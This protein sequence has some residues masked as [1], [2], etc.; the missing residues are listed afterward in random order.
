M[1]NGSGPQP[2]AGIVS[3]ITG[4]LVVA[5]ALLICPSLTRAATTGSI[6]GTLKDPSGAV[7][8]GASIIVTNTAQGIQ[9]KTMTDDKGV[10]NFPS[11]TVGRYNLEAEAPGFKTVKRN[12]LVIDLDSAVQA[13]LSMEMIEKIEE[14]TVIEN[15]VQIE[16]AS[17]QMGQVVT[18]RAMT[19]VALNGR[20]F[21]DLLALQA[22]IVPM[23]T[24]T[25]DSIV[26]AGAS[27]AIAPSGG[28]AI[29]IIRLQPLAEPGEA[30]FLRERLFREARA[31]G[32]L[33][34]SGSKALL[35]V[36]CIQQ[37]K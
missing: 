29:K 2:A 27:V 26:M 23:S 30:G 34:H 25:P 11:L 7:I 18:S 10:F 22:V 15:G 12:D 24:Q 3:K 13:D 28:L 33:L 1:K 32:A 14:V 19:A 17:T 9:T 37:G 6:F 16:T 31:A 4:L 8:P 20:S 5:L 36:G 21:T 35:L